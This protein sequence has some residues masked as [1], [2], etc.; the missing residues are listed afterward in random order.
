MFALP[1]LVFGL[2][3]ITAILLGTVLLLSGGLLHEIFTRRINETQEIRLLII[4][5]NAYNQNQEDLSRNRDELRRVY[6][7]LEQ[8]NSQNDGKKTT[9]DIREVASEVKVLHGLVEQLYSSGK[10]EKRATTVDTLDEDP[11]KANLGKLPAVGGRK[12]SELSDDHILEI[13]RDALRQSRVDLF[14]QPIVSLPQRKRRFFESFI[15]MR[16][17]D[18]AT[19][20][21]DQCIGLAKENDLGLA[22]D[23]MLL[24][25]SIQLLKKAQQHDYSTA[26]FCNISPNTFSDREF[27]GDFIEYL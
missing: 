17:A 19:I 7:V 20:T 6:E 15:H 16:S 11:T 21:P 3:H 5:R 24:F 27:F 18:G 8:F 23:N 22:I 9:E 12:I 4:L 26:F 14:L 10:D 1:R 25:R 2:D 13:V